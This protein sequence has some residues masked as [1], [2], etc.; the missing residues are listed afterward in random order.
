MSHIGSL[1]ILPSGIHGWRPV[2]VAD[3][4]TDDLE[5]ILAEKA[6]FAFILLGTG[7]A[8]ALLPQPLALHL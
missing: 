4:T 1:L 8:M 6:K 7:R 2:E 3:I 5:P